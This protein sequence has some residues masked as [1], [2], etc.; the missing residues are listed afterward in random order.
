M[1][2]ISDGCMEAECSLV[3]GETAILPDFYQPGDFDMA[4]L[5]RRR[6][7]ARP[8]HRRP[9]TSRPATRSSAWRRA[10][11]TPTATAWC[12]RSSSRP[13]GLKVTRPRA[14]T[15]QDGRRGAADADAALRQAG[16]ATSCDHYPVKKRVIRGLANI[17][18]G[19][20]PD[21]VAPHPAAGQAGVRE[22]RVVARCRRCSAGCRSSATWPTRRCSASST[23]A[24][25]SW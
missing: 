1:K 17:T 16:P 2:G 20:L 8:H 14:G 23:W 19:G 3:G 18:G 22:A 6:R 21:N 11:S 7:R 24:S 25:A 15:G 10:A 5:L 12:A 4:G 9:R 13:R